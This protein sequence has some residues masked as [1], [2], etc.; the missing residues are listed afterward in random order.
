M[1]VFDRFSGEAVS[2]VM[3]SQQEGKKMQSIFSELEPELLLLGCVA[4]PEGGYKSLARARVDLKKLTQAVEANALTRAAE[5]ISGGSAESEK[6]S[7]GPLDF[8]GGGGGDKPK[9]AAPGK[10]LPFS[11]S[12]QKVFPRALE[13]SD[14]FKSEVV[15][16]E[17]LLLAL[18]LEGGA[19]AALDSKNALA[20]GDEGS[21]AVRLAL[22][23]AGVDPTELLEELTADMET[24]RG[25]AELVGGGG[26]KGK[27]P[28]LADCGVDLTAKARA[29]E[30]D[31][32][33]GRDAEVAR[34]LQILVRRRKSNPC[35][36]GDPGVGKTAI[37][38]REILKGGVGGLALAVSSGDE[39]GC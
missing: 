24:G 22:E 29:G 27:T 12:V 4:S 34:A 38:K 19:D 3:F 18:L 31:P 39:W 35:F 13:L 1:M 2:A 33:A 8:F 6:K 17:H 37:G 9:S 7:S 21:G 5:V 16:S 10:D 30:L 28:A 36:I 11:K 26:A 32:V 20:R 23:G 25:K 14:R 15:R